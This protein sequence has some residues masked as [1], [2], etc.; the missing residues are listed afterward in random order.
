[1]GPEGLQRL[2]LD[3]INRQQARPRLDVQVSR[4][5]STSAAAGGPERQAQFAFLQFPDSP[6]QPIDGAARISG[7]EA[8]SPRIE[9]RNRSSKSVKYFEIGWIVK[10]SHGKEF[11][12][13][14]VP[15][16]SSEMTLHPGET[17]HTLQDKALRFSIGSDPVAIE[18]MTGFVSQVEYE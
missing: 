16:S 1:Y 15:A 13:A 11:W 14:S 9:G 10:D 8:K 4:G 5:R 7:S 18:A 3:S 12:A 17:G 6:V 2:A